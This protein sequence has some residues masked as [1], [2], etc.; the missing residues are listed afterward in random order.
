ME[1]VSMGG[2]VVGG[3]RSIE[4]VTQ[5]ITRSMKKPALACVLVPVALHRNHLTAFRAET[6]NIERVGCRVLT[7]IA[8]ATNGAAAE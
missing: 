8:A 4:P 6:R 5:S 1:M 7:H 3:K 2:V